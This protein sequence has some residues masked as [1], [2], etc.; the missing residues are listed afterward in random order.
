VE[1]VVAVA[2][3]VVAAVAAEVV[4]VV[5]MMAA[6]VDKNGLTAGGGTL[7]A[8]GGATW[9]FMSHI[10]PPPPSPSPAPQEMGGCAKRCETHAA[11]I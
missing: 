5:A 4:G 3:A 10:L 11:D 6:R 8:T 2:V 7:A 1:A 9:V